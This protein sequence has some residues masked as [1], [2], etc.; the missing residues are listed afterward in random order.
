MRPECAGSN[1]PGGTHRAKTGLGQVD[2]DLA[3]SY[4]L[5]RCYFAGSGLAGIGAR[6]RRTF[7]PRIATT[8]S[9]TPMM[10]A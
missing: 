7:F 2:L 4:T 3:K 8:T 10:S 6:S 5:E 9:A 1:L